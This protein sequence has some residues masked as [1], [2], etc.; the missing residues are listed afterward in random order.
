MCCAIAAPGIVAGLLPQLMEQSGHHREM[1][2]NPRWQ[3]RVAAADGQPGGHICQRRIFD[4]LINQ[5]FNKS[6]QGIHANIFPD[7][8]GECF[9][10]VF[11][12]DKRH[13]HCSKGSRCARE[14]VILMKE[15]PVDQW[16]IGTSLQELCNGVPLLHENLTGQHGIFRRIIDAVPDNLIVFY[17]SMVGV[18]REG[19]RGEIEGVNHR[20]VQNYKGCIFLAE[21]REVVG[22][23][24]V[25]GNKLGITAKGIKFD[26]QLFADFPSL[27][28]DKLFPVKAGTQSIDFPFLICFNI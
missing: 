20:L 19:K 13:A 12:L 14:S 7:K 28:G 23:D 3:N 2:P 17:Q 11:A 1:V 5:L 24:I 9:V 21:T 25:T 26:K 16:R 10:K 8:P 15:T 27:R 6:L 18:F 22:E 4:P